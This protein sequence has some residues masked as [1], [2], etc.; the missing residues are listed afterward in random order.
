M[1][2]IHSELTKEKYPDETEMVDCDMPLSLRKGHKL[3]VINKIL[4]NT[5]IV[6]DKIA[7]IVGETLKWN[8]PEFSLFR[9]SL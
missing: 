7:C 5:A 8:L 2:P 3:K 1:K 4:I 6:T 9:H